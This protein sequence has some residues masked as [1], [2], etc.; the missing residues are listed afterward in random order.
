MRRA[1][2][3]AYVEAARGAAQVGEGEGPMVDDV[4]AAVDLAGELF[5]GQLM[6]QSQFQVRRQGQSFRGREG[7]PS[8][9]EMAGYH[10]PR[11]THGRGQLVGSRFFDPR[12]VRVVIQE[13][14]EQA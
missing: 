1:G 7:R 14:P 8:C 13:P 2:G 9:T 11:F 12:S 5:S 4:V 6:F 10:L 3:W